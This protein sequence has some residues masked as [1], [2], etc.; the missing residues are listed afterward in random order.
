[1]LGSYSCP[2]ED[3]DVT[4]SHIAVPLSLDSRT[5]PE[6][7]NPSSIHNRAHIQRYNMDKQ[8]HIPAYSRRCN[9]TLELPLLAHR[10]R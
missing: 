3:T 8:R 6:N 4:G 2:K 5:L 9:S 7:D 10:L 1:M